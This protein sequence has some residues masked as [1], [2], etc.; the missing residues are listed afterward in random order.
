MAEHRVVIVHER[1]VGGIVSH[2]QDVGM[3]PGVQCND[4]LQQPGRLL[5]VHFP[6]VEKLAGVSFLDAT[7]MKCCVP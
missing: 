6:H 5:L 2:L 1:Q 7:E 3:N 4:E